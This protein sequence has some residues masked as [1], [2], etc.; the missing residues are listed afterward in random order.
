M[1]VIVIIATLVLATGAFADPEPGRTDG[2]EGSEYGKGGYWKNAQY[3]RFYV[4]G[5]MGS[6]TVDFEVSRTDILAGLNAGYIIED[7]L[8]FQLGYGHISDQDVNLYSGG[9]RSAYNREPFNYYFS[10]DAELYSPSAGEDRFGIVPGVGAEVILH[11]HL[12]VGLRFQRDF[13]FADETIKIN[14]FTAK[15]QVDF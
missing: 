3:G 13:I 5:F 8:G 1:K 6:A 14:K 15:V 4:E 10:L 7:W 2:S 11:K 9:I 12:R